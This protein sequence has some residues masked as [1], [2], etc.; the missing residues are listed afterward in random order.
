MSGVL[1]VVSAGADALN[2][3]LKAAG[4]ELVTTALTVFTGGLG[5]I[6]RFGKFVS[7]PGESF[8]GLSGAFN[9]LAKNAKT[10]TGGSG[11]LRTALSQRAWGYG[12]Y[13]VVLGLTVQVQ[14]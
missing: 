13:A 11:L 9:D 10:F 2:G 4:I 14:S 6:G 5:R 7:L 12:G 1:G 3:N 8:G